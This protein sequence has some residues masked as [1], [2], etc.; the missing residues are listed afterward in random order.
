MRRDPVPTS[1]RCQACQAT[2]FYIQKFKRPIRTVEH[3]VHIEIFLETK[4]YIFLKFFTIFKRCDKLDGSEKFRLTNFVTSL[5][6]SKKFQ[7]KCKIWS[8]IIFQYGDH[9]QRLGSIVWIFFYGV[10]TLGKK[11]S[12]HPIPSH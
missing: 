4:F 1:I 10:G 5:K 9:V 12:W 2:K 8:P 3:D 11:H 6:N 7:K